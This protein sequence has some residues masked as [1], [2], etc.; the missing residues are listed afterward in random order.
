MSIFYDPLK[1]VS[2]PL[3]GVVKEGAQTLDDVITGGKQVVGDAWDVGRAMAELVGVDTNSLMYSPLANVDGYDVNP[4]F[5]QALGNEGINQIQGAVRTV[6]GMADYLDKGFEN[7]MFK[8][9]IDTS[10]ET[11]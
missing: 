11:N 1:V 9:K 10:D 3:L 6:G 2:R 8:D 5:L 7:D 4:A